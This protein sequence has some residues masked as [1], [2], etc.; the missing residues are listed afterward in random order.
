MAVAMYLGLPGDGKSMSGVRKVVAVLTQ[1][2][3]Y[4]ITNLPLE[5]GEL[6][7]YLIREYGSDFNCMTRDV[8]LDHRQVR[9]F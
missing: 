2:S 3:R 7:D 8:C 4:V 9:K 1:G 6:R 5:M